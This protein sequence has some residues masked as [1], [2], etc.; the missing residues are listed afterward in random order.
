MSHI[1]TYETEIK[2]SPQARVNGKLHPSWKL[3]RR[4][5][6][7]VAEERGG[8]VEDH[9]I[10]YYGRR[11]NVD[12]ALRTPSFPAGI[13]ISVAGTG[14]VRFVYDEYGISK[15]VIS[16]LRQEIVQ[17][18]TALAVTEALTSLNYD[19]EF[20]ETRNRAGKRRVTVRGTM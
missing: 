5:L 15:R 13:G 19:V 9:I 17:S 2:L 10:D 14:E 12:F 4:A 3:M 6:E 20:D 1:S 11:R 7:A 16:D 18:Y 8:S